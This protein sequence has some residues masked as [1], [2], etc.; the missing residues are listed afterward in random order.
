MDHSGNAVK[1]PDSMSLNFES[2]KPVLV[3][4]QGLIL[5]LVLVFVLELAYAFGLDLSGNLLVDIGH[6]TIDLVVPFRFMSFVFI[7]ALVR[8]SIKP[9]DHSDKLVNHFA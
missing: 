8:R 4:V 9:A 1:S 3:L 5:V 2:I 6:N 7:G